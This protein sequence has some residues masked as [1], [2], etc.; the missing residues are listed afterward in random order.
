MVTP[1]ER[2]T[3]LLEPNANIVEAQEELERPETDYTSQRWTTSIG[4]VLSTR[5]RKR[6]SLERL[7][8]SDQ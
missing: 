1:A 3:A 2:R 8:S 7:G 4:P 6:L 5:K